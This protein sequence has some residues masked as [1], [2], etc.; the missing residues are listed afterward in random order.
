MVVVGKQSFTFSHN[1]QY[2]NV[3]AFAKEVKGFP[4]VPI[5]DT[6]IAYACTSSEETHLL[7]V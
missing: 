4:A 7:V 1:G 3:Q 2:A 5:V 6:V